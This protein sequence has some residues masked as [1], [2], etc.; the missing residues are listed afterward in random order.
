MPPFALPPSGLTWSQAIDFDGIDVDWE[1]PVC[2]GV[3]TNEVDPDDWS[4]YLLL[5]AEL[6]AA[7][8]AAYP[9]SHK[10]LTIAMGM[11]LGVTGE[12]PMAELGSILDAI[13]LM[14]CPPP[15]L[16]CYPLC[17]C[18]VT[19]LLFLNFYTTT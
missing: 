10:E 18:T 12:A 4:N 17:C 13:N 19:M 11:P 6:R 9:T 1:Y 3:A 16:R 5:L 2:C 7:M 15:S 14:T 8:D